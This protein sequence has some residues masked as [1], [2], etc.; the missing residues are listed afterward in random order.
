MKRRERGERQRGRAARRAEARE[1]ARRGRR[2]GLAALGVAL[3]IVALAIVYRVASRRGGSAGSGAP[4]VSL[5]AARDSA[6]A[7]LDSFDWPRLAHWLVPLLASEPRNSVYLREMGIAT[8]NVAWMG[9][10]Y[11]R[12][13]TATRTSLDR[14]EAEVRALALLD[15]AAACAENPEDWAYSHER[16]GAIY[17]T[18]GLPLEALGI[19]AELRQRQ[20]G[21]TPVVGRV[22]YVVSLLRDPLHPP[23]AGSAPTLD[24][25]S[26]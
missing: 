19:Y 22:S 4:P 11:G 8:H 20:P 7:A 1:A 5:L 17:E 2:I 6:G 23:A 13:R 25:Q 15:S 21:Y 26:R 3:V 10:A 16:S 14:V 12:E 24:I 18:L 9:L